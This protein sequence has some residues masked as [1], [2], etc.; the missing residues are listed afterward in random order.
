MILYNR[1]SI[2]E[3]YNNKTMAKDKDGK[4]IEDV[5]FSTELKGTFFDT[6]QFSEDAPVEPLKEKT[7]VTPKKEEETK[8]DPKKE[9]KE[10][11]K[12][13]DKKDDKADKDDKTP[14]E[15]QE[16]IEATATALK[17]KREDEDLDDD[18]KQFLEDYEKGDLK[19]YTPEVKKD[20]KEEG[21][22]SGYDVL[23]KTLIDKGILEDAEELEDTEESFSSVITKTVD[24]KVDDYLAEIPEEYKNIID[25]MRSGGNATEYLQSKARIDYDALDLKKP[26]I[27][28]ALIR[29]DLRL[30]G[31]SA[32]DIDEKVQDY[33]DLDKSEKE[34]TKS[35]KLFSKQQDDRIV[36][37]DKQIADGIKAQEEA[38]DAEVEELSNAID[39]LTEIAGFKLTKARKKAFKKYLFETDAEGETAASRSSKGLDNRINLYFMDFVGYN[40]DDLERSV[41]TKKTKDFSKLLSRYRDKSTKVSGVTVEEKNPNPEE[42]EL[43]I[44]SM[45]DRG[46]EDD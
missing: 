34:A 26:E 28:D 7:E 38:E 10:E 5:K 42:Q 12:K 41:T 36:V 37:Y 27:Q 25:F 8:E 30:Q 21:E 19:D 3:L 18:E 24:K 45:F 16:N 43:K 46:P 31:Y 23:A 9:P 2:F 1:Y 39:K 35:S 32:D 13:E 17:S 44:P 6:F 11:P 22:K 40:F 33:R 29:E 20:E 14:E 15:I 4:E